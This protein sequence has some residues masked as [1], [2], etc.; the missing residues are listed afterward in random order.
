VHLAGVALE[1][2]NPQLTFQRL[3]PLCKRRLRESEVR[4]RA[5][6]VAVF[7]DGHECPQVAQFHVSVPILPGDHAALAP[8]ERDADRPVGQKITDSH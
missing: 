8:A 1:K 3:D 7:G 4:S 5:A 6:V 2:L